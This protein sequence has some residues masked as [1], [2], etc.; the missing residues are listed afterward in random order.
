MPQPAVEA[1]VPAAEVK[2]GTVIL[3]HTAAA[4]ETVSGFYVR[5]A[6]CL[7]PEKAP[8]VAALRA[9]GELRAERATIP[10][11]P[12]PLKDYT[13]TGGAAQPPLDAAATQALLE[14]TGTQSPVSRLPVL[15]ARPVDEILGYDEHGLPR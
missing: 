14:S 3:R 4:P 8:V 9:G 2:P 15:D 12:F 6:N 7:G 10:A 1:S 11:F 5:L 13:K